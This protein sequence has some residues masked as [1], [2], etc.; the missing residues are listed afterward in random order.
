MRVERYWQQ[1]NGQRVYKLQTLGGGMMTVVEKLDGTLEPEF[2]CWGNIPPAAGRI[3]EDRVH[4]AITWFHV[5]RWLIPGAAIVALA[6]YPVGL[7][8]R[9]L[10]G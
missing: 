5:K 1:P 9:W 7:C 6:A 10:L 3:F 8:L 4:D 2:G